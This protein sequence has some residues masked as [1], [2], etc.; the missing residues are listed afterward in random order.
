MPSSG[1]LNVTYSSYNPGNYVYLALPFSGLYNFHIPPQGKADTVDLSTM[2][3]A[4]FVS[5]LR[6]AGYAGGGT[7]LYGIMDTTNPLRSLVIYNGP[8]GNYLPDVEYPKKLVQKFEMFTSIFINGTHS[9]GYY[10]YGDTI[11]ATLYWPSDGDYTLP[12]NQFS[13]FTVAFNPTVNPTDYS[14]SWK[15]TNLVY[16]ITA[17]SDT[18]NLNPQSMLASLKGT[19]MLQ[20]Q[21]LSGLT[22]LSFDFETPGG[23]DYAGYFSFLRNPP[24]LK[25]Q[26]LSSLM[27][28]GINY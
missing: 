24:L 17:P 1:Y 9:D 11:P 27:S 10:C 21:S 13:S 14:V 12:S 28:Y 6:P 3:T 18:T 4:V 22:L 25:S 23:L 19:K 15:T 8:P 16:T 20:G 2:D 5:Y 26:H 7:F